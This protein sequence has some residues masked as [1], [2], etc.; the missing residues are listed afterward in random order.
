VFTTV[1]I[2]LLAVYV[3]GLVALGTRWFRELA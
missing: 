3:V 1:Y 2:V